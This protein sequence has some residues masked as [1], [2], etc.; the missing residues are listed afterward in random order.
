MR[1]AITLALITLLVPG[2][3]AQK[4]TQ[5]REQASDAADRGEFKKA[6]RL[7]GEAMVSASKDKKCPL[8]ERLSLASEN[9]AYYLMDEQPDEGKALFKG[10]VEEWK[11]NGS[12]IDAEMNM[13]M[14]HG[15]AL[16]SLGDAGSARFL[17]ERALELATQGRMKDADRVTCLQGLAVCYQYSYD[18]AKAETAFNEAEKLCAKSDCRNTKAEAEL[19]SRMALLFIDQQQPQK[20]L[21]AYAR[22]EKIYRKTKDT[23]NPQYPVFLLE[24]G[25]ALADAYNYEKALDLSYKAANLDL[26]LYGNQSRAYAADLNNLGYIYNRMNRIAETEQYYKQSLAIKKSL[27][28]QRVDSYLT[29][30]SNLCVFYSGIGRDQDAKDLAAELER[31]L[32]DKALTDTLLRALVANNLGILNKDWGDFERSHRY[33]REALKYYEAVYGADNSFAAQIW[34][35]MG[36]VFLVESRWEEMNGA[37]KNAAALFDK[38]S[39]DESIDNIGNF[40]NLAIIL[41]ELNE[42]KQGNSFANRAL[43]LIEKY[44]VTQPE[45]LEQVWL[46]KAQL[47][48]DLGSVQESMSYFQKFLDLKYQELEQKFGYMTEQEK[49]L[50]LEKFEKDIRNYYSVILNN[51]KDYPELIQTLLDFRLRTKALLLNNLSKIRQRVRELNDPALSAKLESM[52]QKRETMVRLMNFNTE[53]YPDALAEAATLKQEADRLEKE[54]SL[55][56]SVSFSNS[57]ITWKEVQKQLQPGEAAIEVFQSYLIYDNN[58]GKGTNYTFIIL[59]ANGPPTAVSIDRPANWE[60]QVLNAYRNG[61][62]QSKPDPSLYARLWQ[63]AAIQLNDCQTLYVSPDGVFN[64]INLNTLFNA[65]SNKYLIEEKD[66]H[67]LSSLRNLKELKQKKQVKPRSA[68]LVGNPRF[69]LDLSKSAAEQNLTASARRGA[70]GFVLNELPGTGGEIADIG[71]SMAA[72][73][74][75]T[76]IFTEE[77][78]TERQLKQVKDPD[79][80]HI[81]THGFFLEDFKEEQLA[82]YSSIEKDYYKNPLL[83]SG[84]FLSGANNTYS[85]SSS[86]SIVK[87]ELEDGMLSAYEAMNLNLDKT[88]LVV[89]SACETGLGKVKNGEGVFGLQRAFKLAG[90]RSTIMSLWAVD[91]EATKQLMTKFY[92]AWAAGGD[93]YG[94]FRQ[95]QLE[96]KKSFPDPSYWGA[97]VLLDR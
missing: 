58:Q 53:Q 60:T 78:A 36:T 7:S 45:L 67:L 41:K 70:W 35:D 28:Y 74:V 57:T 66:L 86:N 38:N 20:A 79:V 65:Q 62:A 34:L 37:L 96:I 89:L 33:F 84:I 69:D 73:G 91:D 22:S 92:S 31:G 24:Y 46:T 23:L 83:R 30:L 56:A 81:A 55:A 19:Q 95:A 13:R 75:K 21:D 93:L 82:G 50:F 72:A 80:L 32:N 11:A 29:S 14:N 77:A 59:K 2:I 97:F 90:A 18:F 6:I 76:S 88:D 51:I 42:A 15:L 12:P 26:S 94:S 47:A 16:L 49:L 68:V 25:A 44:K 43:G 54:V 52:R 10:I 27:A 4:T 8:E 71:K 87:E 9:A 5:L 61:M 3:Y 39:R 48:A 1:S 17:L 63:P 85:L 64:Q 40:C